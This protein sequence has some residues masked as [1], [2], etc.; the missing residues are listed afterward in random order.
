MFKILIVDD[1]RIILNGIQILLQK[2]LQWDFTLDIATAASALDA[3]EILKHFTPDLLLTDIR[4]PVMNG[5]ELIEQMRTILSDCPV[6]LL[7]SHADFEYAKRAISYNVVDFLLKP[8]E[9]A[10][11]QSIIMKVYKKKTEQETCQIQSELHNIRNVLLYDFS[12]TDANINPQFLAQYFP[13][14]YFTVCVIELSDTTEITPKQIEQL[15]S[16]TY[17]KC[18]T[19]FFSQKKQFVTICNHQRFRIENSNIFTETNCLFP[20][21]LHY[22]AFSI[23]TNTFQEIHSLYLNAQQK[24]L[25]QKSFGSQISSS[26]LALFSYQDCVNIFLETDL[27][28]MEQKLTAYL[29]KINVQQNTSVEYLSSA[30]KSFF[31]NVNIY[32]KNIGI[33]R[34]FDTETDS[35]LLSTPEALKSMIKTTLLRYRNLTPDNNIANASSHTIHELLNYIEQNYMKD[36]SLEMLADAVN[37]HPN[38]ICSLFSKKLGQSFLKCL[39]LQRIKVAKQLLIENREMPIENIALKVGYMNSNQLSRIFKKYE[40]CSPSDYRKSH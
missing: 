1:E 39:H 22:I 7:T 15:F 18:L 34:L 4:M 29:T 14:E 5:F 6:V 23:V 11:L 13:H 30:Y 38:Y 24:I 33:T 3:L 25:Y 37:M 19:F 20:G 16:A 31:V 8:I 21:L 26:Q 12:I 32:L 9:A 10:S 2:R 35:A 27:V 28:N 36:I 40:D 17:E